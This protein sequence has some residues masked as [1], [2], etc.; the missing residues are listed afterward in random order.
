M[1]V[2]RIREVVMVAVAAVRKSSRLMGECWG[3]Y[4]NETAAGDAT[5]AAANAVRI[6]MA[7]S[8]EYLLL[9]AR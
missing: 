4:W 8:V 6:F 9:V 7:L 1:G 5:M 3:E 2:A